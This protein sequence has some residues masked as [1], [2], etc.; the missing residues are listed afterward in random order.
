MM[1]F[2]VYNDDTHNYYID[3]LLKS[4]ELYGKEFQIIVFHKKDI[5][6]DFNEKLDI[7]SVTLLNTYSTL[8]NNI[9]DIKQYLKEC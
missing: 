9:E 3:N 2:L 4:V 1:Y 6:E 8:I 7:I 5:N